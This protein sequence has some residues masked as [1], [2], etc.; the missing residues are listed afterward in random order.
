M[1]YQYLIIGGGVAGVTAAETIREY[2]PRA[3]IAII[4]D[5]PHL[6]YSRVLLPN[7]IKKRIQR[8]Q[9]FLR[10]LD[11]FAKKDIIL[12]L[13]KEAAKL[14]P[15]KREVTLK[16]GEVF[17]FDKLLIASGGKPQPLQVPGIE[18]EGIFRFQTLDDA[19]RMVGYL[20]QATSAVVVGGG[21]ISLEFIEIAY[22]HQLPVAVLSRGPHFFEQTLDAAGGELMNKNFERFGVGFTYKD[23]IGE[24]QGKDALEGV[25]TKNRVLLKGNFVGIGIGLRRNNDFAL[26]LGGGMEPGRGVR[27]NEFLETN[28]PGIFAA[29]DIGEYFDVI[30][31][32]YCMQGNWTNAVLQGKVAGTNMAQKAPVTFR[33]VPSYSIT[34]LGLHITFLGEALEGP[35]VETVS[36]IAEFEKKYERFFFRDGLL[37]GAVMINMFQDKPALASLIEKK[38][39]VDGKRLEFSQMSFDVKTFLG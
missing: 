23:E 14:D 7:Y 28:V 34:N 19:D 18:K 15:A 33:S 27:T 2:D 30:S 35:G 1:H 9:V 6:L 31:G 36:R 26:G 12:L 8:E 39:P 3:T 22:T 32:R 37:I 20:P 25:L 5:E 38:I 11:H 16:S 10:T 21:F 24:F 29:G 4:S 17:S 13:E